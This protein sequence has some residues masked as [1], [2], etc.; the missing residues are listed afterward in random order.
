MKSSAGLLSL[1]DSLRTELGHQKKI[2]LKSLIFVFK[3]DSTYFGKSQDFFGFPH[4]Y[5]KGVFF[6][7]FKH[8][9][10]KSIIISH[11]LGPQEGLMRASFNALLDENCVSLQHN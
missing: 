9:G 10:G 4:T 11:C 8:K 1:I 2:F 7:F 6:F 3:R 5:F